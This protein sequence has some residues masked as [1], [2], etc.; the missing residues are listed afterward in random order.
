MPIVK[1]AL[2]RLHT[3]GFPGL[4]G[5]PGSIFKKFGEAFASQML[6]L[7]ERILQEGPLPEAWF[8]AVVTMIPKASAISSP[9]ML[10]PIALQS[11][12]QKWVTNM[13]PIQLEDILQHVVPRQQKGFLKHR[14]LL[15][16]IYSAR[17]TWDGMGEGGASLRVDFAN[18]YR[19]M[20]HG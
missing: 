19:T 3:G 16:H 2:K 6:K 20:S 11:V 9:T 1:E 15:D 7:M 4:D 18:A 17:A 10:R 8:T 12:I 5:I 14:W 13:I